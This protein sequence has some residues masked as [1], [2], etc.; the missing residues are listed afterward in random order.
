MIDNKDLFYFNCIN[1]EKQ[2]KNE[3]KFIQAKS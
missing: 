3:K 2:N 1:L